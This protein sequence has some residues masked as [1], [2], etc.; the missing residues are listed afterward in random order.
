MKQTKTQSASVMATEDLLRAQMDAAQVISFDFFDTLFIRPLVDPEDLFDLLG[1]RFGISN[2]RQ[3]RR[4]AQSEAFQRMRQ[5]GRSEITL[6][7]IYAC[8]APQPIAAETLQ[9]AE[10]ELELALVQPNPEL[11]DLYCAAVQSGKPVIIVSD[12]YLPAEFFHQALQ[13]HQLQPV[14]LFISADCN[15]TKRDHGALFDHVASELGV[16]HQH[17]LHIGDNPHSDVKQAQLKGLQT[18]HYIESRQPQAQSG[19]PLAASL[20]HGL[21]RTA[22]CNLVPGS[23]QE[24]GFL[25]GGPAAVGF[26]DWIAEQA[27]NE[28]VEHVLFL[29]RDGYVLDQMVK[30]GGVPDLPRCHYLLGSRVAFMLAA[31]NANNFQNH[32]PE[33]L[34]GAVGLSPYEVLERI[35]V[36]VPKSQVMADLGLADNCRIT[37]DDYDKLAQFL[38]AWRGQILQ[39]CRKNRQALFSYLQSL[40][41]KPGSRVALVDVGWNG[42]T[43]QAFEKAVQP[44]MELD[45]RGYYF[46]LADTPQRLR[47][48]TTH[49]MSALYSSATAPAELIARIY[50][51][52]VA[53]ELFFSAP[54]DAVIGLQRST[55]GV[56]AVEDPGRAPLGHL[57]TMVSELIDGMTTFAQGYYSQRKRLALNQPAS[58]EAWPLV[59]LVASEKWQEI[60]IFSQVKNFDAWGSSRNRVML[61]DDYLSS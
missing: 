17:I 45:V 24:L 13:A 11:V 48:Q 14:P 59:D 34:A 21:L 4:A 20:A 52:R 31:I 18:F 15:A 56:M 37:R 6:A 35:G 19:A 25:Y 60:A 38:Y 43:Q 50:A 16:A 61:M 39:V 53:V 58:D 36:P 32:I 2:F 1:Q 44:L 5:A 49:K 8:F 42:T 22:G 46:C 29:A 23:N 40:E 28:A 10:Y 33:L 27:K 55:E 9:Q 7:G 47:R 51:N 26:L 30:N 12:M 3:L 57:S 41:I 54:H